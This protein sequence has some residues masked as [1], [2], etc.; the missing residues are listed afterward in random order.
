MLLFICLSVSFGFV[1][2]HAFSCFC[3]LALSCVLVHRIGA[4][5]FV[6]CCM[7]RVVIWS[8]YLLMLLPWSRLLRYLMLLVLLPLWS[9]W[10]SS[11]LLLLLVMLLML[12]L[13]SLVSFHVRNCSD[14]DTCCVVLRVLV[15]R[16]LKST[17]ALKCKDWK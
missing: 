6:I 16:A 3:A 12:L 13:S 4:F 14:I 9:L 5:V 1:P 2:W 15:V 7:I 11:S 10:S 8:Y 17:Q